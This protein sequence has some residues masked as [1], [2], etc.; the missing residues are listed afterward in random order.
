MVSLLPQS[1]RAEW[2]AKEGKRHRRDY[3][4]SFR[5]LLFPARR[6]FTT[7]WAV[8]SRGFERMR[9][10]RAQRVF[11]NQRK[12]TLLLQFSRLRPPTL[13]HDDR[14]STPKQKRSRIARDLSFIR[15]Y[16][17][18]V[19]PPPPVPPPPG[20][21]PGLCSVRSLRRGN[22][23]TVG[24]THSLRESFDLFNAAIASDELILLRN[25]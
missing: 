9:H 23:C 15:T 5:W 16:G 19:D 25:C 1:A 11:S 8:F 22:T 6:D 13:A 17:I 20:I 4:D 24:V 21:G 18:T 3:C 12:V 10:S 7:E 14:Q 2:R